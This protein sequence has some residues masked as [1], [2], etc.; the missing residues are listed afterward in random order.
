MGFNEDSQDN[1]FYMSFDD[2]CNVFRYLYVCKYYSVNKWLE[3][4][5]PGI[6]RKA[7]LEEVYISD[8]V[9]DK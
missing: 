8:G 4:S 5:L 3:T 6:W 7:N 9:N 1:T 2:F